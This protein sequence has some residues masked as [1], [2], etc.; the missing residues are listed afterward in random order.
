MRYISCIFL[1]LMLAITTGVLAQTAPTP[2]PFVFSSS[3]T[4]ANKTPAPKS[5]QVVPITTPVPK[6]TDRQSIQEILDDIANCDLDGATIVFV[7]DYSYRGR[8]MPSDDAGRETQFALSLRMAP[9]LEG[10]FSDIF[11]RAGLRVVSADLGG[12]SSPQSEATEEEY[13]SA[14]QKMARDLNAD[15]IFSYYAL[16]KHIDEVNAR[17]GGYKSRPGWYDV[18]DTLNYQLVRVSNGEKISGVPFRAA[19]TSNIDYEDAHYQNMQRLTMEGTDGDLG[20]QTLQDI[21][22]FCARTAKRG[23]FVTVAVYYQGDDPMPIQRSLSDVLKGR[24]VND[25]GRLRQKQSLNN[26]ESRE[27]Y[28]EYEFRQSIGADAVATYLYDN[29]V[30]VNGYRDRYRVN[31]E[32]KGLNIMISLLEE[33]REA[34]SP[35]VLDRLRGRGQN[36][37]VAREAAEGQ[38]IS[39]ARLITLGREGTCLVTAIGTDRQPAAG[40]LVTKGQDGRG[41]VVT[42][43]AVVSNARVLQ[44]T[45]GSN[46]AIPASVFVDLPDHNIAILELSAPVPGGVRPLPLGDSDKVQDRDRVV[47]IAPQTSLYPSASSRAGMVLN[48]ERGAVHRIYHSAVLNEL[49]NGA[50]L[51]NTA[52]EVIGVCR[53]AVRANDTIESSSA[54]TEAGEARSNTASSNITRAV[55]IPTNILRGQIDE[56]ELNAVPKK[57]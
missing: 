5:G 34:F 43:S 53:T 42:D 56:A 20:R 13:Y 10:F 24:E 45:F 6:S 47:A 35:S 12:A 46:D 3:P 57:R 31:M 2:T 23:D 25:D 26:N 8:E 48:V 52:G 1:A 40:F 50:P 54:Q 16:F 36:P 51:L 19:G 17:E 4:N 28:I 29:F 41:F 7:Y 32:T 44:V 15:Y 27:S 21:L 38:E 18:Q 11:T 22:R 55:A 9:I 30:E 33:G 37:D 14:A 49:T 39:S